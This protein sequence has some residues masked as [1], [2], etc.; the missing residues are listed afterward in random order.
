MPRAV[1]LSWIPAAQEIADRVSPR[2]DELGAE[3]ELRDYAELLPQLDRLCGDYVIW[4]LHRLGWRIESGRPVSTGHLAAQLGIANRHQRLLARLLEILDEDGVF[5][6]AGAESPVTRNH[7]VDNLGDRCRALLARYPA[8][9]TELK[10]TSQ[11]GEQLPEVLTGKVDPLHLLFPGG[12]RA[13]LERLYRDAPLTRGLNILARSVFRL[14]LRKA[15]RRTQNQRTGNR[16]GHGWD[17][18]VRTPRITGRPYNV[19]LHRSL[20]RIPD[21]SETDLS[22][23]SV[24]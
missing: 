15:A 23:L 18:C 3:T 1:R 13:H 20:S 19:R 22:R 5:A 10:L 21:R 6:R 7:L 14:A 8:C 4:A 17:D 2:V 12:S 9:E 16:R 11:C 24:R